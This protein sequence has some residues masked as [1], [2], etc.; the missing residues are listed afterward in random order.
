[1]P[2]V[3]EP[4]ENVERIAGEEEDGLRG[5]P[6]WAHTL[7]VFFINLYHSESAV[8]TTCTII[9]L[10]RQAL[11]LLMIPLCGVIIWEPSSAAAPGWWPC[12]T[13]HEASGGKG[14]ACSVKTGLSERAACN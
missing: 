11:I 5:N 3:E 8:I 10:G 2:T 12:L 4:S 14:G 1:M 13:P 7:C 9:A 6:G